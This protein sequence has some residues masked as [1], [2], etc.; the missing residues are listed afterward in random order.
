[1]TKQLI[2]SEICR[3]VS[4]AI[5]GIA[6]CVYVEERRTYGGSIVSYRRAVKLGH[7]ARLP[8]PKTKLFRGNFPAFWIRSICANIKKAINGWF[9]SRR[10]APAVPA[11]FGRLDSQFGAARATPRHSGK[12]FSNNEGNFP[13]EKFQWTSVGLSFCLGA[14]ANSTYVVSRGFSELLGA[15]RRAR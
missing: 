15:F 7:R 9:Q 1:M 13:A 5:A 3:R 12:R 11:I 2:A 6:A 10:I 14:T 8:P 4:A